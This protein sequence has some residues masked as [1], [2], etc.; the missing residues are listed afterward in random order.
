MEPI[1]LEKSKKE[2][3]ALVAQVESQDKIIIS[4]KVDYDRAGEVVIDLTKKVK[5]I[6]SSQFFEHKKDLKATYDGYCKTLDAVIKPIEAIIDGYKVEQKR[7][8]LAEMEKEAQSRRKAEEAARK[9]EERKQAELLA[10][11]ARAEEKGKDEKAQEL[12]QQ[13]QAV[14]V[15]PKYVPKVETYTKQATGGGQIASKM[16]R[17]E[18]IS[19]LGI[20]K[21]V[22]NGNLDI[23]IVE[24]REAKLKS[25]L[26]AKT[27]N[28]DVTTLDPKYQQMG[29]RVYQDLK[30]TTRTA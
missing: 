7:W 27:V 29:F 20:L 26:E 13:A 4:T 18:V 16:L 25:I 19:V 3:F 9:E 8:M 21:N 14:F 22:V 24:I 30:Q 5:F 1:E 28:R 10:R 23:S 6:K 17:V 15:V 11:S 2:V 12:L